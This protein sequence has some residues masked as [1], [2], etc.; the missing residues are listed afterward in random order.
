MRVTNELVAEV[1]T[2]VL[3]QG[4][5]TK[6]DILPTDE[7]AHHPLSNLRH[8]RLRRR[9]DGAQAPRVGLQALPP[10]VDAPDRQQLHGLMAGPRR[11]VAREATKVIGISTVTPDTSSL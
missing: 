9:D 2:A 11:A 3:E 1:E 8:P 4:S 10:S 7:P 5:L 6:D